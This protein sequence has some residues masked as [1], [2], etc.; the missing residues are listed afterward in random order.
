METVSGHRVD[1]A[2]F[3][4]A[5]A[6]TRLPPAPSVP[7]VTVL[8]GAMETVS[9]QVD[10]V[11]PQYHVIQQTMT[12]LAALPPIHATLE[13]VIVT[14]TMIVMEILS[15]EQITAL[16]GILQWIVVKV[17]VIQQTMTGL[18]AHPP[19]HATLEKV[20]VIL[21]MIVMEILFVEQTT[22][23][24]GI[25]QWIV[26]LLAWSSSGWGTT[27][28]WT[29]ATGPRGFQCQVSLSVTADGNCAA[30]CRVSV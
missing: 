21:T 9:G 26:V 4:S 28:W 11:S 29:T 14:M 6:S 13:K 2:P 27:P 16:L 5:V 12:G 30:E 8:H 20:I 15:V 17:L 19:I 23:L 25:L 7:K 3:L 22:A 24:L 18:A 1:S 10:S